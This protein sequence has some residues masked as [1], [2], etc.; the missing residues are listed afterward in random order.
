MPSSKQLADGAGAGVY[1][2][3]PA[4]KE[5][6]MS[7]MPRRLL[8]LGISLLLAACA[9]VL[10]PSQVGRAELEPRSG[11]RALGSVTFTPQGD[12]VRV[13]VHVIGL[14]PGEHGFHIHESGDCSAPDAMSAKG[15][16]NPTGKPHGQ[17]AGDLPNLVADASGKVS[18]SVEI[19]PTFQM[20]EGPNGI[21]GRSVVI[22][23]NGDDFVS[24]PAGNSGARVACGTIRLR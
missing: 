9:S 6:P 18:V 13:D 22:H 16:F 15:H 3:L 5:S 2:T 23:A 14:T 17:H 8:V 24:Q 1:S 7:Q 4:V 21:I 20:N 11:S 12:K 10:G 19:Y